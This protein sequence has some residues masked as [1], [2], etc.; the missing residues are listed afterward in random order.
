MCIPAAHRV[1]TSKESCHHS[2]PAQNP[3]DA[4]VKVFKVL[5]RACSCNC[6]FRLLFWKTPRTSISRRGVLVHERASTSES[7][8]AGF[9]EPLSC[10]DSAYFMRNGRG[11]QESAPRNHFLVWI[12]KSP[13]CHSTDA[14]GGNKFRR[15]PTHLRITSPFSGTHK[16]VGLRTCWRSRHSTWG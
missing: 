1:S 2:C 11:S 6:G 13:G 5:A 14:F 10:P 15:V 7:L 9:P 16:A 8:R 3:L 12:V 4:F